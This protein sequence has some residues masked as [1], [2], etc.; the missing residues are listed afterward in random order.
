MSREV[1]RC[2]LIC[3]LIVLALSVYPL[4]MGLR[5]LHRVLVFGSVPAEEYPKY[6]IPYAPISLAALAA[7]VV[8]P[9]LLRLR[10]PVLTASALAM[11]VFF[12]SEIALENVLVSG[13]TMA[14]WQFALCVVPYWA[15]PDSSSAANAVYSLRLPALETEVGLLVGEY[16]PAVK[17]HFYMISAVLIL[18]AVGCCYGFGRVARTGDRRRVRLLTAQTA[19]TGAFLALCVLACFTAFFRDGSIQVS[20]LSAGLMAVFFILLG[21][22][23]GLLL[24]S[25]LHSQRPALAFGLSGLTAAL[26]TL[27]M[28]LGEMALLRGRLY[29]FGTGFLFDGLGALTLSPADLLIIAAAGVLCAAA[30]RGVSARTA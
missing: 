27:L 11:A 6:V 28:Y 10:R 13:R 20:P 8:M 4:M 16:R 12:V 1:K 30:V 21:V 3:L 2:W 5:I 19:A 9:W 14:A 29:R 26:V 7:V 25:A 17:L 23:A 18:S 15:T 22:T 24:G